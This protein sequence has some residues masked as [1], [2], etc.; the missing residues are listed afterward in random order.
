MRVTKSKSIA[1]ESALSAEE[2]LS[3][4]AA[5]PSKKYC[6][7][8]GDP[9]V[10]NYDGELFH[11]QEPGI[12]TVVRTPD[13]VF[14][15]QE[16]MRK[17][18]VIKPG[19][20]SCMT[21]AVVHYK[22]MNIEVDVAN[23]GKIL[24]NGKEVDLPEDFT[25][26]FGGVQIRYGKQVIEWKGA[27]IQ[28]AGLKLTTPNGFSVMITGGYC[29]VL[30]TNVPTDFFGKMEGICG[31][32][33][34]VKSA[35]DYA[36][37]NGVVLN[38][39]H[40]TKKWE[41][42]GYDGPDSPL[43][44]WQLSWKPHGDECYFAKEC[45]NGVQTRK[46]VATP[47]PKAAPTP[48]PTPAP[49]VAPADAI[50][51]TPSVSTKTTADTKQTVV[52]VSPTAPKPEDKL[53]TKAS[54]SSVSSASSS[55]SSISQS[56]SSSHSRSHSH[57]LPVCRPEVFPPVSPA[58]I[59]NHVET[60]SSDAKSKMSDLYKKFKSMTDDMK[61]THHDQFA[62]DKKI[63]TD[64]ETKAGDTYKKYSTDFTNVET[65]LGK[66]TALNVTLTQHHKILADESDYLARLKIFKPKFLTS[67]E[68]VK[69][70]VTGIKSDI[71]A[72]IIEGEDKKS[73]LSILE[74]VRA[75]TEKSAALLSKAFMDH[76]DK[77]NKN[78]DTSTDKYQE[79]LDSIKVL[80][81]K[82]KVEVAKRDGLWKE[83]SDILAIA[84]KLKESMT[85]SEKD[86]KTFD[87]LMVRVA[88]AF[89]MNEQ[90]SDKKLST[91]NTQCAADVLKA[92][93]D[94]NRV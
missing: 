37:P 83:Y 44:K 39:N 19:V 54:A 31:N 88:T 5:N 76:Y 90:K 22:Q 52:I 8:S 65:I 11:I 84:K 48:A 21:G 82:Y 9:H 68:N 12:Y 63:V 75:S 42:G 51:V 28:P 2:F 81:D 49:V 55:S 93:V 3:K 62:K 34:G 13:T 59:A 10:T 73:L 24:V 29:G 23:F 43:S 35:T 77:Y 18:G 66:I 58:N 86:E 30:E 64:T 38:V 1:Q 69:T 71:H 91:P 94:H 57:E 56:K 26:T 41:M 53:L 15:I 45:E 33:D 50:R 70:H 74:D 72:T 61:K 78:H 14:E 6:V 32:A 25:L 92:H 47:A 7:A 16:K 46:V 60:L 27:A 79:E 80:S 40:G 36:N 87:D 67:L 4:A 85:I 17:N 89:Q 20:P